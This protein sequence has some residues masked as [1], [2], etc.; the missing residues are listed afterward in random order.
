M[1]STAAVSQGK[2]LG[3]LGVTLDPERNRSAHGDTDLTATGSAIRT[4]VITAREDLQIARET[5][6]AA[7]ARR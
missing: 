2:R 4:L 3:Y 6:C 7:P 5:R 1:P